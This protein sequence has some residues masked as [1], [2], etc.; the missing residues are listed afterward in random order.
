MALKHYT[1]QRPSKQQGR[2][3]SL[4]TGDLIGTDNTYIYAGYEKD[5]SPR[6]FSLIAATF[7]I[8]TDAT[9]ANRIPYCNLLNEFKLNVGGVKGVAVTASSAGSTNIMGVSYI[10]NGAGANGALIGIH[11]RSFILVGDGCLNVYHLDG[12]AGDVAY[13]NYIFEYLGPD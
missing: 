7:A 11:P 5:G 8:T 10:E 2:F 1:L 13:Y 4:S 3:I 9:V 12:K 6:N